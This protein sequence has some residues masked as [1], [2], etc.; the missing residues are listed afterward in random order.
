MD[1]GELDQRTSQSRMTLE[2]I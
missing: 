2:R 1:I